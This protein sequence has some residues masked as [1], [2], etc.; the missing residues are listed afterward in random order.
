MIEGIRRSGLVVFSSLDVARVLECGRSKAHNILSGMIKKG[1]CGRIERDRYILTTFSSEEDVMKIATRIVWPSYI[2]F[3]TALSFHGLTEQLPITVF[4]VS[5]KGHKKIRT[6]YGDIVFVRFD[7][8]RFFGYEKA[9]AIQIAEK[10]KA[11]VDSLLY[12]RYAGGIPEVFKCLWNGWGEID[13]EQLVNYAIKM[14]NKSL[15]KRLGYLI[16]LGGFRVEKELIERLRKRIGRGYS[17]L[18]PWRKKIRR[19]SRRWG[20]MLNVSKKELMEWR[21]MM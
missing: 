8:R 11:I 2:S 16:E 10:E 13:S 5:T 18:E 7:K 19:Y 6:E 17:L 14:N 15:L 20:L 1:I 3:W 9:G 21:R 4:V 12:S